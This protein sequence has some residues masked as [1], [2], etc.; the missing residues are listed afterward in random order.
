VVASISVCCMVEVSFPVVGSVEVGLVSSWLCGV[1]RVNG[2][3]ARVA[4]VK[5]M[6]HGGW[7]DG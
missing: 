7:A 2:T 1:G 6:C 5:S 3:V 4:R